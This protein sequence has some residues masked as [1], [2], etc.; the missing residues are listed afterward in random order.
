MA[1]QTYIDGDWVEGN[2]P[3]IGAD[4]HAI[5]LG[6]I[7]FDG[8]R[9]FEGVTPDLDRHCQRLINSTHVMNMEPMLSAGEIEELALDGIKRFA[10]GSAL[11]IRP[12]FWADAAL[13]VLVPDPDSTKFALTIFEAAMPTG[14]GFSCCLSSY[15]RPSPESAPTGA[16]AS[17][18]YPNSSRALVEARQR[19]YQNPILRDGLGHVAEFATSN[20]WIVK[21]GVAITPV[22][23]GSFLNG[24]TRQRLIEL[25]RADGMAVEERTVTVEDLM[26]ADEIFNTGNYGKVQPVIR[27]EDRDLQP[28]PIYQRTREL[29]WDFA[30]SKR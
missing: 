3:L 13:D 19:G 18:H 7:T 16:K 28:G 11:Y 21:D 4:S 23:N 10:P 25:M 30:H 9:T 6:S 12:M 17:C 8:A 24:I 1:S 26:A 20:L 2:V 22:P 27:Y 5:W 14:A 15:R 29:Y